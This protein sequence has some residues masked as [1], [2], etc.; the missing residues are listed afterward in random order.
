MLQGACW[1]MTDTDT[2]LD[3]LEGK[4]LKF[5][6]VNINDLKYKEFPPQNWLIEGLVPANSLTVLSGTSGVGK[7]W[8]LLSIA[9]SVSTG[10]PFLEHFTSTKGK[11]LLIEE[12]DSEQSVQE[13]WK[14]LGYDLVDNTDFWV[15]ARSQFE[16][17]ADLNNL[18]E[19][20][21]ENDISLVCFDTF[22]DIFTGD[23]N[24]S[25]AVSSV[26]KK[27]R[28]INKHASVLITHHHRKSSAFGTKNPAETLR[29]SSALYG[30]LDSH[31]YLEEKGVT[32]IHLTQV[33][34]RASK[35][36]PTFKI[37]KQEDEYSMVFTYAGEVDGRVEVKEQ[38]KNLVQELF[39]ED[40][41]RELTVKEGIEMLSEK[42]GKN[43]VEDAMLELCEKDIIQR[44]RIKGKGN[45]YFYALKGGD[46][47][48]Q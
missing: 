10:N 12:E 19:F 42:C 11:V 9:H 39:N 24:D 25:S 37:I 5:N 33:K 28:E 14:M 22:R 36:H 3:E 8:M 46:V 32:E 35:K 41:S 6:P 44:Y 21:Q 34:S 30:S 27:F 29:G 16:I 20:I 45:A 38:A 48:N 13:R 26:V 15:L 2:F 17:L 1:D 4:I 47:D 23:E 7:T 31:L 40:P 18:Q 43:A